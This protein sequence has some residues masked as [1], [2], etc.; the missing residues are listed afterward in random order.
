MLVGMQTLTSL[1]D[2]IVDKNGGTGTLTLLGADGVAT[3][4]IPWRDLHDRARRMATVLRRYGL[5]AG[6]RVGLVG[7]TSANLVA[8]LQ[9]VWLTGGAFTVLPPAGPT[10]RRNHDDHVRAVAE[11]ARL[12]LVVDDDAGGRAAAELAPVLSLTELASAAGTAPPAVPHRPD[13]G[14]LALLQYTSGSTRSPRGVPVTHGHLAANVGAMKVALGH[15]ASHPSRM[16]SWLPLYHDMGLIG[17]LFIPLSCGCDLLLQSPSA[18]VRNPASWLVAMSRY[19]VTM[20]GAPN[21]A[22]ALMARL[23]AAG[24]PDLDLGSVRC[25]ISGGEPIDEAVMAKLASAGRAVGLDPAAVVP[26]YGLAE[27]TLAATM[28]PVGR[29]VSVDR[30]DQQ[31]LETEGRAVAAVAGR[32]ERRL[33]RVG[34][35]VRD[36]TVRIVDR[37]TGE[38]VGDRVVGHIELRGPSIVGHYWPDPPPPPDSWLRTGDLGYLAGGELVVCGREKDVLFAA[39]RNVFPQ[40]VEAVAVEVSGVRS[41]GAVAF[42]VPRAGGDGLV[43]VVESRGADPAIVRH[44]VASAVVAEVGLAPAD[45]LTVSYGRLPK[46]SSGKL[47]RAEARRRYLAGGFESR[48]ERT[49]Q[50]P[51]SRQLTHAGTGTAGNLPSSST[52]T[53]RH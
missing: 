28:A 29:G 35:P 32:P 31:T 39:G 8:A 46:T 27:A 6:C 9:A 21:F 50:W 22:Y 4:R 11:D 7:E 30:V 53:S 48:S 20:S 5:G 42:G 49:D 3:D 38:P 18:F 40:D 37:G 17:F 41:G 13:P 15:D 12:D 25:L 14:D 19:R 26:A 10:G 1:V 33:V 43:V 24:G 16:L 44:A 23:L 47:R 45:V 51:P 52:S 36:V 2:S 34:G